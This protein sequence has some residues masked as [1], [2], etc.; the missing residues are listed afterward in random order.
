MIICVSLESDIISETAVDVLL[1]KFDIPSMSLKLEEGI[2]DLLEDAD[3]IL[4]FGSSKEFNFPDFLYKTQIVYL[5]R[6][7]KWS[8]PDDP[9]LSNILNHKF[10]EK[11]LKM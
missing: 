6:R 2:E 9:R 3:L 5:G 8:D 10:R 7:D 1:D 11:P 4:F